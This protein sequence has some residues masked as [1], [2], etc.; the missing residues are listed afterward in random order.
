LSAY[1]IRDA[2]GAVVSRGAARGERAFVVDLVRVA[3]GW[4]LV[5]VRPA[6]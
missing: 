5:E 3:E 1:E 4:R 2:A 6:S